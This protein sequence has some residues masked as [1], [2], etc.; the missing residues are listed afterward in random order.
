M[1]TGSLAS[2]SM[3]LTKF[4]DT[5][6][7]PISRSAASGGQVDIRSDGS[8]DGF[9]FSSSTLMSVKFFVACSVA[10]TSLV[11]CTRVVR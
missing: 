10:S 3:T 2:F 11:V 9:D 8:T 5:P 7:S 6:A 4:P 1:R